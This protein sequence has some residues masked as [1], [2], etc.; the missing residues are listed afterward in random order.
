M[1]AGQSWQAHQHLVKEHCC[2]TTSLDNDGRRTAAFRNAGVDAT[3]SPSA[4][5]SICACSCKL[6]SKR[7]SRPTQHWGGGDGHA[8]Q[9][10]ACWRTIAFFLR[11]PLW[12]WGWRGWGLRGLIALLREGAGGGGG[13]PAHCVRMSAS[14]EGLRVCVCTYTG[15]SAATTNA[16]AAGTYVA[17]ELAL[18]IRGSANTVPP[19]RFCFFV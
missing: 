13:H 12:N 16:W 4:H 19:L 10:A 7:F 2:D 11:Q 9:D 15:S 18:P 8:S 17:E 3:A 14:G 5:R 1:V 6:P